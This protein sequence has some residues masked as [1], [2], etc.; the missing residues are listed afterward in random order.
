MGELVGEPD[1]VDATAKAG[2]TF[3]NMVGQRCA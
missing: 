2:L 3:S 1:A